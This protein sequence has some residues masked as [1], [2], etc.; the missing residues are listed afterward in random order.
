MKSSHGPCLLVVL[1]NPLVLA[2][3]ESW[4]HAAL[5]VGGVEYSDT[6]LGEWTGFYDW[7][8]DGE[9]S[10]VGVRYWTFDYTAF[11]IERTRN[12][13][14][15]VSD[16]KG[17]LEIYFSPRRAIEPGLS[18]DQEFLYDPLFRSATGEH[19]IGF[20]MDSLSGPERE[21]ILRH[22]WEPARLGPDREFPAGR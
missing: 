12:L 22:G 19:A 5:T 20:A 13:A 15:V 17:F 21:S 18:A 1:A 3:A 10:V 4:P 9:R 2:K 6:G 14:Y 8:R 16:P 11:L 7:L